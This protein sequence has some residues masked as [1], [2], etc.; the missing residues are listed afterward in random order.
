MKNKL[1]KTGLVLMSSIT[2]GTTFIPTATV[3]ATEDNQEIVDTSLNEDVSVSDLYNNP[4]YYNVEVNGDT[5]TVTITDQQLVQYLDDQDIEVPDEL[6]TSAM[7]RKP[8]V[9]KVIWHGA[10]KNGNVDVYLSKNT[11]LTL[12][13]SYVGAQ[14]VNQ[15]IQL[16]LGNYWGAAKAMASAIANSIKMATIKHGKVYKVRNWK[17]F[18]SVNQ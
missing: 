8:G 1:F 7:S 12:R 14:L 5:T 17:S 16:Y 4:N 15:I 6:R 2:L 9:T 13:A 18:T 3:L 11:L 10:A